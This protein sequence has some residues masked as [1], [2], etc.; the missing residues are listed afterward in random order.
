M[1]ELPRWLHAVHH[2]G[3]AL[4]VSNLYPRLG[5]PVRIR[6][7]A[8]LDA[9]LRRVLIRTTPDG[10]QAFLPMQ[11]ADTTYPSR[12]WQAELTVNQPVLHY[13]F[14]LEAEDGVWWLHAD[15]ISAY[16]PLDATDFRLLADY[17]APAWLHSAVFYQIFPDRF[18]NGDPGNDP[19][20]SEAEPSRDPH[21]FP[22]GQTP[23]DGVPFPFVFYGGD[24]QG[25]TQKLDYVNALGINAL[26]LN[27]IFTAPSNHKYDVTDYYAVDPHLGGDGALC[28]LR[29][30]LTARGMRYVLDIVPNHCGYWHPWFQTARA[31][32]GA[33]EA[34]YFT[35]RQHPDQYESWLGVW[36]LP[37][38]NYSSAALRARMYGDT[39]AV[40]R[41][42]LAPP[43]S[44][45]G[46]RVDV[47]N[48]LGRQGPSQLGVAIAHGIRAAVK[49]TRTDAYL[50]GE[51]FFDASAQLQGDQ[52]DGMMNYSGFTRPVR[53]WLQG[54]HQ[55]AWGL[56]EPLH[57]TVPFSTEA[58]VA[59]WRGRL[60]AI[61]W[62]IA[63]QQ[64]NLLDSHDTER[65]L[66]QLN[67]NEALHR[68]AVTLLLTFP[69]VP[70]LYYGDEIGMRD[71]SA[72]GSRGCMV[73][74]EAQW[75]HDLLD[76]HRRLIHLRRS[77]PAL[78]HGS[79]EIVAVEPDL[80]AYLRQSADQ[81]VLVVA[82][83]SARSRPAGAL[84]MAQAG[85]ADGVRFV[86]WSS[87]Q[88]AEV[89]AGALPLP[90]LPQGATV[91]IA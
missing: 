61:P 62:A 44:T 57:S 30:A 36:S 71:V 4:F 10:E 78:Q 82:Q 9:P 84:P 53:H 42:W 18:A 76:F 74:D 38:L 72:L 65:I 27:P 45:D 52:F 87:G 19:Q 13:R 43:Y 37:K 56:P 16:D 59:S 86:E 1:P 32:A 22:W 6:L 83:R 60:A 12:W 2:D 20:P 14:A 91:W 80:V 64:F 3:S 55:G 54:F 8:G 46:W 49:A 70:C 39:D 47:A 7:R 15:G 11:P 31:D 90:A 21:T 5:D 35:F 69:G 24:L 68:L 17:D 23:A 77:A 79:F 85:I 40:F 51:N 50:L 75:N 33:A 26:Y 63:L 58:L 88:A 89:T 29:A 48:M 66:T 41:R 81:R 25:I 28:E 73:W 67:D 34:S